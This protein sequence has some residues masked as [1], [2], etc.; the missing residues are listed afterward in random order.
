[1]L[2]GT[3]TKVNW[4][5][6]DFGGAWKTTLVLDNGTKVW[7]SVPSSIIPDVEWEGVEDALNG[8]RVRFTA[9]VESKDDDPTFGFFKRPAKAEV[10]DN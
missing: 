3:L 9:T 2:E 4:K 8:Q 6:N 7:G 5:S 1:V 10:L